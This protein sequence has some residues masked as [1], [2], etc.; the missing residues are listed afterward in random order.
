MVVSAA[1]SLTDAFKEIGALF[2][3]ANPGTHVAFNF[4]S[5]DILL[6]Q[7]VKGAP[8]DVFASADQDAMDRA[9]RSGALLQ[10]SRRDFTTNRLVVIV[11]AGAAAIAS[12]GDLAGPQ[13]RRIAVGSPQSVP[14]GRYA[15]RALEQAGLWERLGP[16]FVFATNVRQALDYVARQEAEAG[17][18]YAT[19]AAI[20]PGKVKVALDVATTLPIRYPIAVTR[21]TRV[22]AEARA[23]IAFLATPPAQQILTRHGFGVAT[24]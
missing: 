1:A 16:R 22:A 10:G 3:A 21:G 24:P 23:F 14:A 17:F 12:L 15:K 20:F 4:A 18:V 13:Y 9:E 11:P 6:T 5:S 2:S 19:D 8:A 7:I